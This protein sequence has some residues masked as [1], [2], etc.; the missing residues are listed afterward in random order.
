MRRIYRED[1]IQATL[2]QHIEARGVP[3]LVYISVPNGGARSAREGARFKA[4]GV[5]AGVADLIFLHAGTA[6]ALEI[7]HDGDKRTKTKPGR[8]TKEQEDFGV[9]WVKAGGR[10]FVAHGLD[11]ALTACEYWGLI[12]RDR[13]VVTETLTNIGTLGAANG[14]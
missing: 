13:S 4:T 7:K 8:L 12:R 11:E 2:V 10:H 6:F 3:G 14:N 1:L 9:R 5:K